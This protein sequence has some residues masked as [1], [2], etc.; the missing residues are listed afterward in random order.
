MTTNNTDKEVPP[1]A[2]DAPER[3]HALYKS[4]I[5]NLRQ[6]NDALDEAIDYMQEL[7]ESS[8]ENTRHRTQLNA[9]NAAFVIVCEAEEYALKRL[10]EHRSERKK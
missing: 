7:Y 3:I 9:L 2:N 8:E 5:E 4:T 6:A 10:A 1:W